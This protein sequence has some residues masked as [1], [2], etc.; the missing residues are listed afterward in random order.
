MVNVYLTNQSGKL[1]QNQAFESQERVNHKLLLLN[2]PKK[3]SS[4]EAVLRRKLFLSS[5]ILFVLLSVSFV[6]FVEAESL[7]WSQTYGGI[8]NQRAL[9]VIET[10]DCGFAMVGG[11]LF[12]KTD[13]FGNMEWNKTYDSG[14]KLLVQTSDGG[15]AIAGSTYSVGSIYDHVWLIKT[16]ALGN[17]EWNRTY[18]TTYGEVAHALVVTSDGGYAI[19]GMAGHSVNWTDFLLVKTDPSGNMEWKKT[20]GGIYGEG[21]SSVL[22]TTDGGY[23]LFG[24]SS[25]EPS[26]ELVPS[27][28]LIVKTD[29]DGNMT[30][31]KRLSIDALS[32]WMAVV[33]SDGGYVIA[34]TTHSKIGRSYDAWLV[35]IDELGNLEWH[36]EHGGIAGDSARSL[37]ATFDGG[38]ALAGDTKSFGAGGTDFWLVKTDAYGNME[39]NQTYGGA[40]YDTAYSL[41]ATSDGGYALAGDT[42]SFGAGGYDCWLVKTDETGI[43]PE[44]SSWVLLSIMLVATF[45]I[46][47]YK[48]KF[49]DD[50]P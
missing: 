24:I 43:V 17:K 31:D 32:N 36:R 9:S 49:F 15:Y 4:G 18:G 22:E 12:I 19:S 48:K 29:A 25:S 7:E 33:P 50:H 46:V 20:Y 3:M 1:I 45:V 28:L 16:D 35:K 10:S 44:Y 8:G 39:W 2:H 34:G 23:I 13:E 11:A 14:G 26:F 6:V 40:D 5:I 21:F 47:I 37:V 27:W 30:W 38:Y 41:V 42:K